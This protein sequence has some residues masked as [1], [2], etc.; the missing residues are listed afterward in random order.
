MEWKTAK[1]FEENILK[2]TETK[3]RVNPE[4]SIGGHMRIK[5]DRYGEWNNEEIIHYIK[6]ERDV[7]SRKDLSKISRILNHKKI[8]QIVHA[9][10]NAVKLDIETRNM[11]K[12]V[13][14]SWESCTK[15]GRSKLRLTVEISVATDCN[16]VVTIYL[17]EF[18]KVNIL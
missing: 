2:F 18:G 10:R 11:I 8:E 12:E 16:L 15:S 13:V 6:K 3:M 14:E 7:N 17:K 1:F 9:Y 5:L 4:L